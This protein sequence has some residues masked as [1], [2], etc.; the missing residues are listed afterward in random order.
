MM[1]KREKSVFWNGS[2]MIFYFYNGD[3]A[4]PGLEIKKTSCCFRV[5]KTKS[6]TNLFLFCF[7][8]SVILEANP[9]HSGPHYSSWPEKNKN[10]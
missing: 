9:L 1:K 6:H 3:K 5:V 8:F 10:F 2:A 4:P 7:C